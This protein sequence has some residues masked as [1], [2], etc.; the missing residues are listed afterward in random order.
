MLNKGLSRVQRVCRGVMWECVLCKKRRDRVEV[1][2][3]KVLSRVMLSRTVSVEQKIYLCG[4]A[5][6]F[7]IS[8]AA[9]ADIEHVK[10]SGTSRSTLKQGLQNTLR[11]LINLLSLST[12]LQKILQVASFGCPITDQRGPTNSISNQHGL[13]ACETATFDPF[14][15]EVPANLHTAHAGTSHFSTLILRVLLQLRFKLIISL[16]RFQDKTP[17]TRPS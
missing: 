1:E 9:T 3:S 8:G 10:D 15:P 11:L 14:H 7:W 4:D 6:A 13:E 12:T 17:I 5:K 2:G 16:S